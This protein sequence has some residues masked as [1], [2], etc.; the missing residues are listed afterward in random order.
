M[1]LGH[2]KTRTYLTLLAFSFCALPINGGIQ[3]PISSLLAIAIQEEADPENQDDDETESESEKLESDQSELFKNYRLLEEKLFTLHEFE[4]SNNPARSKLLQRAYIQSQEQLTTS[5]MKLIVNLLTKGRLKDAQSEQDEVL[6]QLNQLLELL[7]SED[8]GKRVRD[9][10]QRNQE[11]LKEVERI[12]RIQKGLRGQSEGGVGAKR[13]AG[14]QQKLAKRTKDLQSNMQ[15]EEESPDQTD[16]PNQSQS[17][18]P[19]DASPGKDG[20][21]SPPGSP[22]DGDPNNPAQNSQDAD[23]SDVPPEEQARRRVQS[24]EERMRSAQENLDQDARDKAIQEMKRAERELA[25]AK[26]ELE[27]ILRQLRKEEVERTLAMLE[28]RFRKMLEREIRVQESTRKLGQ[29]VPEQ[30]GTEFEIR[31]GKLA[32][33]QNSIATQAGRA[34]MVLLEDGSS[35]AFPATVEEMQQDML[36]VGSRLSAAKV[37]TVTIEIESDIIDTLDYLIKALIKTQKDMESMKQRSSQ[38]GG[39]AGDRPLV[40]QL[41]EIKMLRGLQ[42]RIL[43]RHR[44]Y[45]KFLDN[46]EDLIGSTDD[47]E[48]QAALERLAQRQAQLTKIA[49]DIVNEKN[50]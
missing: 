16:D 25:L 23:S 10:I 21:D 39:Q 6:K 11:Y 42:D 3:F 5:Q 27:E 12:L 38:Q 35:V 49:R 7:Q 47:P 37:G 34:L 18:Q 40:D 46:P 24:A 50:K 22:S 1:I 17:G 14:S 15:P 32:V 26:K 36:Q 43:R 13:L 31:A 33:E 28:G 2:S 30:R 19:K 29:V 8:R 20:N 45:S 44:R 9:A 4:R 48:L 41:A